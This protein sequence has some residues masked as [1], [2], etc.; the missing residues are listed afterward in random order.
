MAGFVSYDFSVVEV[1]NGG[2][3]QL[4]PSDAEL[5]YVRN[6][7]LVHLR[8]RELAIEGVRSYLTKLAPIGPKF[9]YTHDF[10]PISLMSRC[11][12]L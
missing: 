7:L 5:C 12:V 2:E 6:P 3:V 9:F 4:F 11:T 1:H 8:C 10:I